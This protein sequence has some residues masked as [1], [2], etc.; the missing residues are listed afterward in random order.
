MTALKNELSVDPLTRGYAAMSDQQVVD[1]L[2]TVYRTRSK[3]TV[4]GS[5]IAN[6]LVPAEFSVLLAPDQEK[7]RWIT[8]L[9]DSIDI[10]PGT[11]VRT[12]LTNIFGAGTTTRS[13]V[14]ALVTENISRATELGLGELKP[15]YIGKARA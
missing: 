7:V 1:D 12:M 6:A 13:N 10:G 15:G 5:Q 8:Q 9:G 2:N 14:V 11:N 4:S 3:P